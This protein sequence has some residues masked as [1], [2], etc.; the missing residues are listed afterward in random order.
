MRF[1]EFKESGKLQVSIVILIILT[2]TILG[3]FYKEL[4]V[5]ESGSFQLFGNLGLLLIIGLLQRWKH[6]RTVLSVWTLIAIVALL[7]GFLMSKIIT[8]SYLVLLIGLVMVF[9]LTTY[10][11]GVKS[12][13]NHS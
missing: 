9:Y 6:I 3:N 7:S 4:F 11:K 13:L 12:Y 10:S 8:A 1:Q 2:I 5:Q